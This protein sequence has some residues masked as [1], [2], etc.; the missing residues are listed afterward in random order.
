ME[1][2]SAAE[3]TTTPWE[4]FQE[5]LLHKCNLCSSSVKHQ[6]DQSP[7]VVKGECTATVQLNDRVI[8]ATFIVV[9]VSTLYLLFG[10]DWVY[11]LGMDVSRLIQ[12]VTQIHN[13]NSVV[14][15]SHPEKLFA[16]F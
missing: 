1:A 2:D 4:V 6:Y 10:R 14:T 7:L 3:S 13:M 9:D 12:T 11:L 15:P 5:K 16:E 8:D